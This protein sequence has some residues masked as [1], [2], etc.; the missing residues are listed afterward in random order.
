MSIKFVVTHRNEFIFL[1]NIYCLIL[2]FINISANPMTSSGRCSV[3]NSMVPPYT[4]NVCYTYVAI[5][6]VRHAMVI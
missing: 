6:D 1:L 5:I 4:H 3:A 2:I